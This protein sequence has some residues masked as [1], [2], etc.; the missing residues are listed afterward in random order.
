MDADEPGEPLAPIHM[1]PGDRGG[2]GAG[3]GGDRRD[4][5]SRAPASPR[6]VRLR[7][8]HAAPA[9]VA[10]PA[11]QVDHLPQLPAHVP[12]PESTARSIEDELTGRMARPKGRLKKP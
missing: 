12:G 10:V 5:R 11:D 7:P 1:A 3:V 4:D 6:K 2:L 8:P 9:V